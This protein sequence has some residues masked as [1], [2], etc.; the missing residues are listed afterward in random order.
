MLS[1]PLI[2]CLLYLWR[3]DPLKLLL[4]LMRPDMPPRVYPRESNYQKQKSDCD[5]LHGVDSVKLELCYPQIL[6]FC[7]CGLKETCVRFTRQSEAMAITLWKVLQS[8]MV[9]EVRKGA[10]QD[11]AWPC[12]PLFHFQFFSLLT[13]LAYSSLTPM[14]R[15]INNIKQLPTD[16][17]MRDTI[18]GCAWLLWCLIR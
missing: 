18:T 2:Y 8:D 5:G 4:P 10:L 6:S 15:H 11:G 3:E 7:G 12:S 14:T 1:L 17:P 13:L 16:R 9:T